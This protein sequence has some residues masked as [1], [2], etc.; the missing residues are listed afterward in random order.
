MTAL[1]T[2]VR[3]WSAALLA[4]AAITGGL[5]AAPSPALAEDTPPIAYG[6]SVEPT[7]LDFHG[8][9]VT[10]TAGAL[11]D[12][13][14]FMFYV[15]VTGPDGF[16]Q[17]VQMLPSNIPDNPHEPWT[18]SGSI[19]LPSNSY[20][21]PLDY[22]FN[23]TV[24]DT[25]G[26][27]SGAY[28]GQVTVGEVQEI[29]E[30]PYLWEPTLSAKTLPST[31]GVLTVGVST[32]D[33]TSVAAASAR[34]TGPGNY[35]KVVDLS[36]VDQTVYS[37]SLTVPAN[38]STTPAVYTVTFTAYDDIGQSTSLA[39]GTFT[40]AATDAPPL[41]QLRITPAYQAIGP[42]NAGRSTRR[43][44]IVRNLGRPGSGTVTATA[45]VSGPPFSI[46]G[47]GP[48]GQPLE[49]APGESKTLVVEFRPKRGGIFNGRVT[50]VRPDGRQRAQIA[51]LIGVALP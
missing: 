18:F 2:R 22:F 34:V 45:T 17:D 5:L 43:N 50:V 24:T 14:I 28:I 3:A 16:T 47:A 39:G 29:D 31:G 27:F 44:V 25:A 32:F 11:D 36:P 49:L 23:S 1:F 48:F 40:V 51:N 6:G 37:G 42:V 26:Q 35:E 38:P 30:P 4:I 9:Q 12:I 10:I 19:T 46:V 7:T 21:Y 15:N 41:G 20:P 13:G 33:D 8:G